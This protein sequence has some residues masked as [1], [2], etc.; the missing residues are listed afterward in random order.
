LVEKKAEWIARQ[1]VDAA[2]KYQR[3]QKL[4]ELTASLRSFVDEKER[5][6]QEELVQCRKEVHAN[7]ILQS[8]DFAFCLYPE[9]TLRPFCTQFLRGE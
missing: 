4:R 1:P 5:W 6:L 2:E 3:F 7:R 8:R 9:E